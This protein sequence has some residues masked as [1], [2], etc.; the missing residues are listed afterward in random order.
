MAVNKPRLK[1]EM[2][3]SGYYGLT[4][5]TDKCCCKV[6]DFPACEWELFSWATCIPRLKGEYLKIER[7][8]SKGV[9]GTLF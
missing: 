6:E 7:E 4:N 9:Q 2:Q 1:H 3:N 8:F 5:E